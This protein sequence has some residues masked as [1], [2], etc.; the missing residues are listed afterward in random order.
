M[1]WQYRVTDVNDPEN[2]AG[3]PTSDLAQA[4]EVLERDRRSYPWAHELIIQ[5]RWVGDWEPLEARPQY[6]ED[7]TTEG[8]RKAWEDADVPPEPEAGW[9]LDYS[10]GRPGEAWDRF[11]FHEERYWRRWV[12]EGERPADEPY[13]YV[14]AHGERLSIEA[15][16]LGSGQVT[17]L[18]IIWKPENE[19][20]R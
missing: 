19:K 11:D 5:K 15:A 3:T 9:E 2:S 20:L 6:W 18:P 17:L 7:A 14:A 8:P 1:G 13:P 12:G 4:N 16:R 10:R